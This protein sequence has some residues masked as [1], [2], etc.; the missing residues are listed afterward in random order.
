MLGPTDCGKMDEPRSAANAAAA[1][2]TPDCLGVAAWLRKELK[3]SATLGQ[4]EGSALTAGRSSRFAKTIR[5]KSAEAVRLGG[6]AL[7]AWRQSGTGSWLRTALTA[8]RHSIQPAQLPQPRTT[9]VPL[10]AAGRSSVWSGRVFGA[11]G[12]F[13]SRAA[14]CPTK[15][16]HRRGTARRSATTLHWPNLTTASAEDRGGRGSLGLFWPRSLGAHVA[17]AVIGLKFITSFR[18][19]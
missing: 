9:A 5:L 12:G 15:Q 10:P 7:M 6:L 13:M 17:G 18:G 19:A 11:A 14:F 8:A 1:L 4:G 16:T 3:P 2:T